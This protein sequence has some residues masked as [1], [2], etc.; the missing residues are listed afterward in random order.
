MTIRKYNT[1][2]AELLKQGCELMKQDDG[3]KFFRKVLAVNLVL[4][5][6]SAATAAKANGLSRATVS[7]WVKTV[8]E[9]GFDALWPKPRGGRKSKLSHEQ[10][11][12]LEDIL[13]QSPNKFGYKVWDGNSLSDFIQNKYGVSFKIRHCQ[14]IFHKLGF[15]RIRPQTFPSKN[16]EHTE[17]REAFKKEWLKSVQTIH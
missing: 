12:E 2:P 16:S 7:G 6:M 17:E 11:C 1:P 13:Q 5:G 3:S 8:N 9:D 4:S 10:Y 15:A 14:N